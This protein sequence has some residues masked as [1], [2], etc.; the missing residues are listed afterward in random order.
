MQFIIGS[1]F[2][3]VS[4]EL[5]FILKDDKRFLEILIKPYLTWFLDISFIIILIQDRACVFNVWKQC[6]TFDSLFILHKLL[7]YRADKIFGL[8]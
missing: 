4:F 8:L 5:M 1:E 3:N 2:K 6:Q 7:N